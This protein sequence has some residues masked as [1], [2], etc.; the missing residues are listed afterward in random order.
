M[1]PDYIFLDIISCNER[2]QF[3]GVDYYTAVWVFNFKLEVVNEVAP[4]TDLRLSNVHLHSSKVHL[5]E[6]SNELFLIEEITDKYRREC[7]CDNEEIGCQCKTPIKNTAVEIVISRFDEG[8]EEFVEA[9]MAAIGDRII[10]AGD[11]CSFSVSAQGVNGGRVFYTD[12]YIC[13]RTGNEKNDD[14][15]DH[16]FNYVYGYE[17][18]T[19]DDDTDC[20]SDCDELCV[21]CYSASPA[22]RVVDDFVPDDDVKTVFRGLN[23]HNSGVYDFE[24][25][26]LGSLLMFP[27]YADVFW[28]PPPSWLSRRRS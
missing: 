11:D 28:R 25:R 9:D 13:F 20:G 10:F 12:K 7:T 17:E 27:H 6:I 22:E 21:C 14:D 18:V 15:D 3:L 19:D 2:G 4:L 16:G 1:V 8:T 24:T 5:V 26:E 23:G